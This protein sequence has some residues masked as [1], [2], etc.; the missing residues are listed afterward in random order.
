MQGDPLVFRQLKPFAD[1]G[2]LVR[3]VVVQDDVQVRARVGG[4]DLLQELQ[5]LLVP[6]A[7]GAASALILPVATSRAANKVVVPFRL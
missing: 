4:G 6:V 1:L 2:V 3:A 5:E 7:G